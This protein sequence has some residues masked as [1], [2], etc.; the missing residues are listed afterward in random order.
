M[1]NP[2]VSLILV[3]LCALAARATEPAAPAAAPV[4]ELATFR[5]KPGASR[6][7]LLA[8]SP[9]VDRFL[10]SCP[11]FVSRMLIADSDDTFTDIVVW[12][13]QAEAD[14]AL[15]K[16]EREPDACKDY[17]CLMREDAG[18]MRH[19]PVLHAMPALR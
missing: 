6:S 10:A 17:L 7:D 1:K 4:V 16:H 3:A 9:A 5:L 15:K 11:G 2:L 14:A 18:T 8:A 19:L 12:R 13:S